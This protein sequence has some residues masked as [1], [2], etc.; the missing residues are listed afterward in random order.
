M[1]DREEMKRTKRKMIRNPVGRTKYM[2]VI[3]GGVGVKRNWTEEEE[4]KEWAV[5]EIVQK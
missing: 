4:E 5:K 2:Q 1:E 3:Q